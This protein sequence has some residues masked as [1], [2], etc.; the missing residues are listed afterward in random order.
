[1]LRPISDKD[2]YA[3]DKPPFDFPPALEQGLYRLPFNDYLN[4]RLPHSSFWKQFAETPA[5]GLAYLDGQSK[6]SNSIQQANFDFGSAAHL[7]ILEPSD[8]DDQ[9]IV[10]SPLSKN[11]KA[12]KEWRLGVPE[13]AL[14]LSQEKIDNIN[15][16][17]DVAYS[18]TFIR[19]LLEAPGHMEVTGI[20]QDQI[21]PSVHHKIRVDKILNNGIILDYKTAVSASRYGFDRAI[22]NYKYIWQSALYCAGMSVI[23]GYNH[24][25]FMFLAQEKEN[26]WECQLFGA[27]PA[28]MDEASDKLSVL[29]EKLIK[30]TEENHW[31]GYPDQ[32]GLS[33]VFPD[34]ESWDSEV[35]DDSDGLPW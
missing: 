24:N 4:I 12:Y 26:P 32:Y 29:I 15:H 17:R 25:R 35:Y 20:F 16:M 6:T 31:P 21:H 1:M 30:C 27:T 2:L 5:H 13:G 18:K 19:E 11:S 34:T 22:W 3:P 28:D 7:A 23:T 10:D 9:V 14:V 8:F 33:D